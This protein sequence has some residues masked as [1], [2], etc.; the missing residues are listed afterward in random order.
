MREHYTIDRRRLLRMSALGGAGLIVGPTLAN[1]F[2]VQRVVAAST[3][4][5]GAAR[6]FNVQLGWLANVENA[7]EF[8]AASKGYYAEEG[9]DPTLTPGGPGA[10]IEPTVVSGAALIGL[11]SAET[12]ARANAEGAR[13]KIVGTTLQQN[14]SAVMSL[15]SNPVPDPQSLEGKKLGLQQVGETTYD[16]FFRKAGV[17]ASRVTIVPVQFDPAPLVAGEV[18]AFA[19]FLNNQPIALAAEGIE[20]VT[21]LLADYGFNTYA[22]AFI[23][24]EDTLADPEARDNVVRFLRATRRG[25]E[26]ALADPAG[27]AQIVV[28]EYGADLDLDLEQQTAQME[29]FVPMIQTDEIADFGLFWMTDEGIATNVETLQSV[30]IEVDETL[31]TNELLEEL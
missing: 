31:F 12:I 25:W 21:W 24:T 1:A 14:P 20:T 2:G 11:D 4:E 3:T 15:A 10:I 23:V 16:A 5:P 18:D 29:A 22:D 28:D 7:G 26:D 6:T 19:S 9:I 27:A 17:D 8:V 13:L 30:D